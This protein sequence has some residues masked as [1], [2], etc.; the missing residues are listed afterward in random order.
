MNHFFT[1]EIT[2]KERKH[3]ESPDD[4][5]Q[6]YEADRKKM[7]KIGLATPTDQQN[8]LCGLCGN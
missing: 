6:V 4:K 7:W 2:E 3:R 5:R 1:T 8:S